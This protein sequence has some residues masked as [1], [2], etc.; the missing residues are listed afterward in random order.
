MLTCRHVSAE[1]A[2]SSC[3]VDPSACHLLIQ[4]T[5]ET[6]DV[7]L[8]MLADEIQHL[9]QVCISFQSALVLYS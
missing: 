9:G 7:K 6:S 3:V 8:P 2:I 4:L 1:G 5:V